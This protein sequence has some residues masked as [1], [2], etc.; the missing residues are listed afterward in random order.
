MIL[1]CLTSTLYLEAV[2]ERARRSLGPEPGDPGLSP[3]VCLSPRL[4]THNQERC[5]L[6]YFREAVTT[7]TQKN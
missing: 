2:R 4:Y 6:D 7:N 5:N 3:T 1:M